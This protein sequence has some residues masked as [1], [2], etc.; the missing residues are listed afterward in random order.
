MKTY[1]ARKRA[2]DVNRS[3]LKWVDRDTKRPFFAF[4]NYMDTHDP[5]LPP[6]PY[7]VKFSKLKN[8]G[9]ILNWRVGR[10]DPKLTIEQIKSE[11]ERI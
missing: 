9:G 2:T 11:I 8:P 4:L 7:R 3:F 1:P 5:Y 10:E 6:K